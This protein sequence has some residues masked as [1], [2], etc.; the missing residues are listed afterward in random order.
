MELKIGYQPENFQCCRLFGPRFLGIKHN[1]DVIIVSFHTFGLEISI[2]YE[3]DKF[4]ISQLF[5]SHFTVQKLHYVV[6]S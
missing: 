1:N 5:G 3:T 6:I 4:E 2:F